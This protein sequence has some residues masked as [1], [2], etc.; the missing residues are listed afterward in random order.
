MLRHQDGLSW[1]LS[2]R[3]P[4]WDTARDCPQCH[5]PQGT[6]QIARSCSL[7][8]TRA[9]KSSRTLALGMRLGSPTAETTGRPREV[10]SG[11]TETGTAESPCV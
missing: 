1:V 6:L 4:A 7:P 9:L 2:P 3:S 5:A 11:R 10:F 8:Q